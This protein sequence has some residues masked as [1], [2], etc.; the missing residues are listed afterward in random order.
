MS[1]QRRLHWLAPLALALAGVLLPASVAAQSADESAEQVRLDAPLLFVKRHNYLGIH[2]YDTYYKWR[3]GG[4]LYVLENPAAPPAEQRVRALIDPTTAETLGE[5]VYSDPDLSW[6]AERVLFCHK[7]AAGGSTSIYEIGIDGT[8]LRRVTDPSPACESYEGVHAGQHDVTPAYLPDGRILFTS[9]RPSGLVPCA[10]EGV[11]IL[12]VM[13][14]DGSDVHSISVNN[15]NEFD[16]CVL[17]DGRILFGRWEYVDKTALTQQS[18]WTIHPD[19]SNETAL[20]ANNLVRPEALL[21]ARPVPGSGHAIVASFT[22]HNGPPRGSIALLDPRHGKNSLA[23]IEN[24]EHPDEPTFDLGESCDPWPLSGDAVL[25][26]GRPAGSERNALLLRERSDAPGLVYADSEIDCHSPIPVRPRAVPPV[27]P[28]EVRPE[29]RVGRFVVQDIYQGLTGVERGEVRRL[30]VIEETSRVSPSPG[31]AYNQTFLVSAALAFSVKNFLGTVPVE[32]DGSAYFEAPAGRALYLQALDEEGRLVQSM[33]TFAQAA[34]G[35]TRSCIGCH[36]HKSSAPA[37]GGRSR[38]QAGEPRVLE[39][40]SWGSGY[41]DYPSMVQPILDRHCLSCHGGEQGFAGGLDL[42]GGWTEHFSNSYENLVSRRD[43]QLVAH[44][45]AGIDCMN[46]TANWSARIF[47]PRSHGSGAAP[48]A[49]V[50][51]SGHDGAIPALSR[52]ERDLLLAWID[53]NGLYHGTWDYTENGFSIGAWGDVRTTLT[54]QMRGAGCLECHGDGERPT[55][56][57][58]DWFNLQ[59]PEL[60]RIL[61]APLARGDDGFGLALCR[62]RVLGPSDQRVHL[63]RTGGYVHHVLPLEDFAP[64]PAPPAVSD[65]PARVSFASTEDARYQAMLDTIREGRRRALAAPRVDM[66]GARVQPGECRQLVPLP[67]PRPSPSL[68]ARADDEGV[69]QLAWERSARTIGLR[70]EVYRGQRADFEPSAASWIASTTSQRLA[71]REAPPGTWHYALVLCS[72]EERGQPIRANLHVPPPRPPASPPGLTATSVPGAVQLRWE[73]CGLPGARYVVLRSPQHSDAFEPLTSE[74]TAALDYRD[75]SVRAGVPHVYQVRAVSRRGVEGAA[76]PPVI[77]AAL[78]APRE[79][80]FR[81]DFT[82]GLDAAPHG[83]GAAAGRAHAG[84]RTA[85]DGL[86]LRQGGHV[87]F[88]HRAEFDLDHSLT[89]TCRV[90]LDE[91]TEMPVVVSCGQWNEAGW[92]LQLLGSTWR[93]H[94]GGIDCDGGAIEL[95]RWTHLAASFDG[96]T[97]RL[98]VDGRP[99]AEREGGAVGAPWSG[100]LHVG[101]YGAQLAERYQVRGQIRDLALYQRA[102]SPEEIA[103]LAARAE[104]R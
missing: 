53:T 27:L 99:V 17:P 56:F 6:D 101:Q 66:P 65:G 79:P 85:E 20:F 49:Q 37:P 39:P 36:E 78:A 98:F 70:A 104:Q 5:G 16:P 91:R 9:T 81:V 32:A 28:S 86:D 41:V 43:T 103:A 102:L 34:P 22:R 63:M 25:F 35:V 87:T 72:G 46:G 14:A 67:L 13:Q 97:A 76:A 47:P 69:V 23:A 61:R 96:E 18:L 19:G 88:A 73:D 52:S 51:T 33:R 7:A 93:W 89:V 50:L 94:A 42:S 2:I 75:A 71:D 26:S 100:P 74:P 59:S 11:A 68:E 24:L 54:E 95:G 44:L 38:A 90:R 4:G 40:E 57:D 29:E 15:V 62:E 8:G 1:S 84:A 64:E 31:G 92:F 83:G 12:H 80:V 10:N 45:I 55:Y 3:P 30:R 60:S 82:G 77:A 21:D 58:G 48:L